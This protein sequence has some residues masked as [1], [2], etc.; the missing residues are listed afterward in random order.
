MSSGNFGS[1]LTSASP[2]VFDA[3][4]ISRASLLSGAFSTPAFA[5]ALHAA[6]AHPPP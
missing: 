1:L 5:M 2:Y 4:A 3:A 6:H